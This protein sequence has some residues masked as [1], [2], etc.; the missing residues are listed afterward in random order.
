MFLSPQDIERLT[1]KK[2]HS[3]QVRWLRKKGYKIEVNGLGEPILAVAEYNRKNVG[4]A[5]AREE[6]PNWGAMSGPAPSH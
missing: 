6:E 5:A 4:G 2:R 3:A 1:G